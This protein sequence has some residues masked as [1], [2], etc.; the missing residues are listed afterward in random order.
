MNAIS[1]SHLS[2][3][4]RGSD[5]PALNSLDLEV[6]RGSIYGFLGPNGAGKTTTVKILTGL[7]QPD[8]GE[9]TVAGVKV[10]RNSL[11]L[12]RKIGYLPQIPAMYK[13]MTGNE[14]L[15]F[16][17]ELFGLKHSDNKKRADMLLDMS[18]LSK[19]A[20]KKISAYS[21]GMVQ[22]LGI[23]QALVSTPEVLFLDEPTSALDPIGRKEVLDFI[24]NLRNDTTVFMST[25]ILHDVERVCDHAAILNGGKLITS[26]KLSDI[27]ASFVSD[28]CEIEFE[29]NTEATKC[30]NIFTEK[31]LQCLLK[32]EYI[33]SVKLNAKNDTYAQI[34][35][36]LNEHHM[37]PRRI[38][39]CR[40]GLEEIFVELINKTGI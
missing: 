37:Y 40:P 17:G 25:H 15:M 12:G 1:C 11:A 23:A 8:G 13:W 32:Q 34:L 19:A 2:K 14:L 22:R 39:L 5:V 33:V 18:G 9:A 38:E 7:M 28:L 20:K 35:A 26:G 4:Y 31:H 3:H 30:L 21:G 16:T 6:A 36:L 29:N 27:T 10:S 24:T